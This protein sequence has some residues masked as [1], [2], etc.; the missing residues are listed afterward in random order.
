MISCRHAPLALPPAAEQALA[1]AY[2]EPHRRYH[3]AAH[4]ADVLAWL[5]WVADAGA[6]RDLTSAYLAAVGH[7]A[8]YVPGARDNEARSAALVRQLLAGAVPAPTLDRAAQLI[9]LT[10]RHGA[11]APEELAGD[12]DA[13]H[14]LDCDTAILGAAPAAFDAYHAAIAAEYAPTVPPAAFRAGR[15]AFLAGLLARPRIFLSDRFHAR[16]DA[17]ARANLA[18]ALAGAA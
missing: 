17:P 2:A 3:N 5:D 7:D 13:A 16:L 15:R 14:L 9:L 12:P 8:V 4:L 6:W 11:I 10:A 1:A 18:R